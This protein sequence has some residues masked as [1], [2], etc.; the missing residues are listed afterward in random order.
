MRLSSVDKGALWHKTRHAIACVSIYL[1]PGQTRHRRGD[2]EVV[3]NS[4]GGR[5]RAAPPEKVPGS[6]AWVLGW[7]APKTWP[8]SLAGVQ[9]AVARSSADAAADKPDAFGHA[10]GG[11]AAAA[12]VHTA[13]SVAEHTAAVGIASGAAA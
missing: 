6:P 7:V 12:A 1:C 9:L 11:G 8:H 4:A 2:L 10:A 3:G 13:G 5:S